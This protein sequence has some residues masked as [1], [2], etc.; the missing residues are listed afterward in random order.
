MVNVNIFAPT[1]IITKEMFQRVERCDKET[2]EREFV[3]PKPGDKSGKMLMAVDGVAMAV[4]RASPQSFPGLR[5]PSVEDGTRYIDLPQDVAMSVYNYM[6]T[7]I[8]AIEQ[9]FTSL[10]DMEA[11]W[12]RADGKPFNTFQNLIGE[13]AALEPDKLAEYKNQALHT[14]SRASIKIC[15]DFVLFPKPAAGK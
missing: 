10:K 15:L 4:L 5:L 7:K 2:L 8:D 12:S 6:K 9:S 13:A 11:R 14:H 1:N 3:F